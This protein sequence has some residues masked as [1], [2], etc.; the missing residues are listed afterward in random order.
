MPLT[1]VDLKDRLKKVDEI[2]LLE[3]LDISSEDLVDRFED[4]IELRFEK[5]SSEL[6]DE[7]DEDE[8]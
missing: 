2:S 5:L 4:F 6:Q 1:F 7:E 3:L 8:Y